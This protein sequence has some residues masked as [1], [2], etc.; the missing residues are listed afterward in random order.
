METKSINVLGYAGANKQFVVKTL[1]TD[2]RISQNKNYPELEGPNPYE[3]IL[4]GF[5]GCINSLGQMV[6]AEQGIA[7]KA[8]QV[9]IS[10]ELNTLRYAGKPTKERAG[11]NRIEIVLKPTTTASLGVLQRWLSEVQSRS[12]VYDNLANATPVELSLFK[13][14]NYG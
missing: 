10:G 3:Y 1:N 6:A 5:A 8:L 2:L 14:Y 4:A 11:F 13:E 12:P 9:E 7:L